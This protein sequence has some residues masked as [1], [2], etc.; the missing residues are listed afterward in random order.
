MGQPLAA[1]R[2]SKDFDV[3]VAYQKALSDE[4]VLLPLSCAR[5]NS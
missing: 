1:A 2:Q 3:V 4:K 5:N